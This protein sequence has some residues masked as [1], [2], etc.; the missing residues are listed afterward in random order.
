MTAAY[1]AD[2]IQWDMRAS[3]YLPSLLHDG[4]IAV[5][6]NLS[7]SSLTSTLKLLCR[8]LIRLKLR[9]VLGP[10]G[11][12]EGLESRDVRGTCL[13]IN[14]GDSSDIDDKSGTLGDNGILLDPP[15]LVGVLLPAPPLPAVLN[16]SLLFARRCCNL[17]V[18]LLIVLMFMLLLLLPPLLLL[19]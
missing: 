3:V 19:G 18:L 11:D 5:I 2:D 12:G 16:E 4:I 17:P 10:D 9:G 8:F 14:R 6:V 15:L 13:L 1:T 7:L